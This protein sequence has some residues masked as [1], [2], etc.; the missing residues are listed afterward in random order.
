MTGIPDFNYRYFR[1]VH[2]WLASNGVQAV[3]PT[4][5]DGGAQ[6]ADYSV[7]KPYGYYLTRALQLQLTCDSWLGLPGWTKSK[8]AKREFDIAL[9]LGHRTFLWQETVD[10]SSFFI[11]EIS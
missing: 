1:L 6:V 9:D 4:E 8:G 2:E 3:S 7:T 11:E 10:N 5:V